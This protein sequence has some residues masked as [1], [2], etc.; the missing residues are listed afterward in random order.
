[1]TKQPWEVQKIAADILNENA[2]ANR[3]EEG[4]A[5][6]ERIRKLDIEFSSVRVEVQCPACDARVKQANHLGRFIQEPF[7]CNGVTLFNGLGRIPQHYSDMRPAQLVKP[8]CVV[9]RHAQ[10]PMVEVDDD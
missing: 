7:F 3:Q 2:E 1:M 5:L 6:K 10:I 8:P 9:I 4:A